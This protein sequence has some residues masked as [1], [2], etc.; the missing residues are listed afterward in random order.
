MGSLS[1]CLLYSYQ[2]LLENF[3]FRFSWFKINGFYGQRM[4]GQKMWTFSLVFWGTYEKTRLFAFEIYWQ[5]WLL[6]KRFESIVNEGGTVR[7][8]LMSS[9]NSAIHSINIR[10]VRSSHLFTVKKIGPW[11]EQCE[12]I[13]TNLWFLDPI[14]LF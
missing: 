10:I 5:N 1:F 11:L 2:T 7:L 6:Q 3:N 8:L 9:R 13:R 12:Q 4:L 14:L